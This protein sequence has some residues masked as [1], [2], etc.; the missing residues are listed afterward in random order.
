[1]KI[2]GKSQTNT[3]TAALSGTQT[4]SATSA[5]S[6]RGRG[7]RKPLV[8][9]KYSLRSGVKGIDVGVGS[10][11]VVLKN[12]GKKRKAKEKKTSVLDGPET[13]TEEVCKRFTEETMMMNR[14]RLEQMQQEHT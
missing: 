3:T 10:E 14:K 11:T 4:P 9:K 5:S 1:M 8:M 2:K 12:V 7:R 6:K 13:D